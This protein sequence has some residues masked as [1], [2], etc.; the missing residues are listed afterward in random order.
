MTSGS[1]SYAYTYF[2][3]GRLM[4][5]TY[6]LDGHS[7]TMGFTYNGLRNI[8]SITY[9][10]GR[11]VTYDYSP[12]GKRISGIYDSVCA[13]SL[14]AGITYHASGQV[15]GFTYGNGTATSV[16]Y[17]EYGRVKGLSAGTLL[18]LAYS[19]DRAG[20]I[21]SITDLVNSANSVSMSGYDCMNRLSDTTGPWGSFHYS[22]DYSGNRTALTCGA[23]TISYAVDSSTNRLTS[24]TGAVKYN[25]YYDGSGNV[26]EQEMG[27]GDQYLYTYDLASRLT[28]SRIGTSTGTFQA[29]CVNAYD[30]SGNRVRKTAGTETRHYHYGI[31][32]EVLS[33]TRPDGTAMTDY[34]YLG[35]WI[36]ARYTWPGN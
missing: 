2:G 26:E 3:D 29:I 28:E 7:Y 10:S 24:C 35:D 6:S 21:S 13:A 5:K 4:G 8:S 16:A 32:N 11:T 17:D 23:S 36:V 20:N 25:F 33:E 34:I 30:G 27:N 15:S 19:Y 12:D 31:S 1:A 22:Y 18:N 14:V 9:P